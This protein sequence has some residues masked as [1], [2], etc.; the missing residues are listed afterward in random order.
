MTDTIAVL[1][2]DGIGP[3]IMNSALAILEYAAKNRWEYTIDYQLFGGAAIDVYGHPFP[4]ATQAAC[5]KADAILMGAIGGPQYSSHETTPEAGLLA[6]RETLKLFANIRP[7]KGTPGLENLSPLKKEVVKDVDLVIVRELIGGIYFDQGRYYSDEEAYDTMHY[8]Y[9]KIERLV[10][11]A[12]DIAMKRRKKL[13]SVDKA[14]V[15]AS[16][17]LW[18]KVVED[19]AIDYPNC[20]VNH[21]YV[22]AASMKLITHPRDFDVIVTENLFGDILS[23][24][25]S[26][27]PGSLGLSPSAS[28]AQNGPNLYEPIHGSAPDIQGQDKANPVGMIRSMTMMLRESFNQVEIATAINRA[29]DRVM[30][31]GICTSDLGGTASTSEFTQA[32]INELQ[33][34]DY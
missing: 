27:I 12:F 15:L 32:V 34:E 25:A 4:E 24:E 9:D 30:A 21:L 26:V 20:E 22:D 23:D 19:V 11:Y 13:T 3:E 6:L 2:G 18:R 16:S 8:T 33:K 17:R 29:C 5:L 31:A 10:R 28:Y 7:I 14:N 1:A